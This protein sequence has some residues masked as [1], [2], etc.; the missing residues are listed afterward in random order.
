MFSELMKRL[1]DITVDSPE[2][3]H[4]RASNFIVGV[5]AMPVRFTPSRKSAAVAGQP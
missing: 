4:N 5:E 3:L 1:P 2:P